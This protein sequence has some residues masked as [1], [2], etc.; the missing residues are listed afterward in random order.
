MGMK[1]LLL[2]SLLFC[3]VHQCFSQATLSGPVDSSVF[4]I[5]FQVEPADD[6]TSLFKR[7]EGWFGGDGIYTIPMDGIDSSGR[8]TDIKTLFIFSDTMFGEIDDGKLQSGSK[9]VNNSVA[10]LNGKQPT[11]QSMQF[12]GDDGAIEELSTLFIPQTPQSKKG[13]YYWLGDGFVNHALDN[14]TYIFGY[15]IRNTGAKVFG[16]EEVGNTLIAIPEG[17]KPPF[18]DYRQFDTPLFIQKDDKQGSGSFGA[19]ILVNTEQ[20][21]ATDPDGFIY[22]YGL[23]GSNKEVLVARTRPEDFENFSSWRYWDGSQWTSD[24]GEVES[25]ADRASNELSVTPMPDGRYVMIFQMDGIGSSVGLRIGLSPVGPFGPIQEV[26]KCPE[27]QVS[28]DYYVYNAK[29]HPHLSEKGELLISYNVN[30]FDFVNDLNNNPHLYRPRFI[31]I[32]FD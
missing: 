19:G 29:A 22:V 16:F 23:R 32:I 26:W 6:W 15:R 12:Y 2:L 1:N 18:A 21:G 7:N 9:M 13:E 25:I 10:I 3:A 14:T 20:A 24:I 28:K 11:N 27:V 8:Q 31:R 17:S 5:D 4:E 30:S